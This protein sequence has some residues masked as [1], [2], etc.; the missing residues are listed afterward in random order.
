MTS[1]RDV[2]NVWRD[3]LVPASFRGVVFH[4]EAS[5][6]AG[7][8]RTVVHE[9]PKRNAPYSE[10]MGRHAIRYQITGY[11]IQRWAPSFGNMPFN[12]D[13]A[14]DNLIRAL[15]DT[16]P[17][18]LV[19]PYNN[20]IG[21]EIFQCERYS[22]TETR[23]RGGYAQFEMAFVEA[24]TGSAVLARQDTLTMVTYAGTQ[25]TLA[26]GAS[27]NEAMALAQ[28]PGGAGQQIR[29]IF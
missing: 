4:V 20:T 9:Y 26:A 28:R 16:G 18:R 10:D 13:E 25:A 3:S 19:D 17:G 14:R 1:I 11:V 29:V 5:S 6:R 21:P 22:C 12:Y 8:R 24:G 2:H 15:E 7:G 23:E 27:M